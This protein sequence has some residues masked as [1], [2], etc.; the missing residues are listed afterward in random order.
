LDAGGHPVIADSP[1]FGNFERAAHKAGFMDVAEELGIP[2]VEL[3]DP[4]PLPTRRPGATFYK[5]EVS[6]R[7]VESDLV[8]NLPKMKTHGQM[9]LTLGVKNLFGCVVAQRKAEW[10]YSVGMSREA[11][12]SLLLDIWHGIHPALTVLDGIAGMDGFGPSNGDSYPYNVLAGARDA[13]KMDFYLCRM[14]GARL[15][16]FPLWQ[17]A[18]LRGMPQCEPDGGDLC[19][20]FSPDYVWPGVHIPKLDSMG[21]I[22]GLSR[23]PFS[24]A[25]ERA[26]ASR[27]A[28]RPEACTDCGQCLAVCPAGAMS[29]RGKKIVIDYNVCIRCYCCQEMCPSRAIDFQDGLV[30][31][32][33]RLVGK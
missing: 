27:P 18:S 9:L 19:G 1:G 25:L 11:F 20:D 17:A 7:V 29:R 26:L 3:T 14:M 10:H 13:L 21:V 5:I 28:H 12:A 32:I 6:R 30:R 16:D 22:P 4:V 24:R 8:I 31:K 15:A 2:C 33:L 23:L